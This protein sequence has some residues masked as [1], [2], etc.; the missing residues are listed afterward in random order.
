MTLPKQSATLDGKALAQDY[1]GNNA[2]ISPS[3]LALLTDLTLL[4]PKILLQQKFWKKKICL[5]KNILKIKKSGKH[6][7]D[8]SDV[9]DMSRVELRFNLCNLVTLY[10]ITFLSIKYLQKRC[11]TCNFTAQC[12]CQNHKYTSHSLGK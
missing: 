12:F 4:T 1:Q 2:C 3:S 9:T 10:W 11:A 7:S 5:S 6:V 8:V